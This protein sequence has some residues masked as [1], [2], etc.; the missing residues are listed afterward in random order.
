MES[1]KKIKIG[2][3]LGGGASRGIAHVAM[4]EAFDELGIKPALI[5]GC[6]IGALIGA[7]YAGGMS[8]AEIREHVLQALSS[9]FGMMRHIFGTRRTRLNQIISLHGLHALNFDGRKLADVFLPDHLPQRIEDF[10]IP[11]KVVTT[12]YERHEEV[13]IS[14][15]PVIDAVGASIAI[16]GI[17]SGP[18][19][20]GRLHLDGSIKNPVPF[21]HARADND[22]VVAIDVIGK[23]SA[24][25]NRMPSNMEV[26]IGSALIMS[27]ELAELRRRVASPD[28]YLT[29]DVDEFGAAEFYRAKE[30][31]AAAE[32][33]KDRLKWALTERIN[34]LR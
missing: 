24:A 7:G 22:L 14:S 30:I 15:G 9:K 12:D 10:P 3:A 20:N 21:D 5:I 29:P 11:F 33:A 16:P 26:L 34:A 25:Q 27:R 31:L 23:P 8:G 19:I 2:L 4:L 18:R 13:L 6:S 32:P 28:I 1:D 17:I